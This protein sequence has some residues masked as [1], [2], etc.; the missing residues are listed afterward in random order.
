MSSSSKKRLRRLKAMTKDLEQLKVNQE[1][2]V[3]NHITGLCPLSNSDLKEIESKFEDITRL[4]TGLSDSLITTQ[5]DI[6]EIKNTLT[7]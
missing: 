7:H 1:V 3:E 4:L 5:K 2:K 6:E